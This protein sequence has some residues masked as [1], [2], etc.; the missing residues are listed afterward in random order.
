MKIELN[1][2]TQQKVSK[3]EMRDDGIMNVFVKSSPIE[4]K[5][6][7][8]IIKLLSKYYDIPKSSISIK[9][10]KKSKRKIVEIERIIIT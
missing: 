10:G 9:T 4:N 5:A 1:V 2:K 8:E 3:V 6:N 7:V